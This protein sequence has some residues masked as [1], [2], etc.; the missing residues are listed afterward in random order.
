MTDQEIYNEF[1]KVYKRLHDLSARVW[2]LEHPY[3]LP[4]QPPTREIVKQAKDEQKAEP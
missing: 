4:L 1:K 3:L 2:E